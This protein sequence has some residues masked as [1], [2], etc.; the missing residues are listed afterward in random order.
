MEVELEAV[1]EEGGD[2]RHE[3]LEPRAVSGEY[4]EIIG[5]ADVAASLETVLRELV[6]LVHVQVRQELRGEIA[7]RQAAPFRAEAAYHLFEQA[8]RELVRYASMQD[9]HER[10]VMDG[11]EELPDVALED[12]AGTRMIPRF[13]I[14]EGA[15][16]VHGAMRPLLLPAGVRVGDERAVYGRIQDAM[17]GMVQQPIAHTRLMDVTRLRVGYLERLV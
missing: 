4:D 1:L 17:D 15:E 14:C 10:I 16:P 12:V 5:I 9:L 11:S 6:E 13:G 8:D 2:L 7:E 3:R